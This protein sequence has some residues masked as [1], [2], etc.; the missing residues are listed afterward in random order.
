MRRAPLGIERRLQGTGTQCIIGVQK[1]D[2]LAPGCS[3]TGVA[4]TGNTAVLLM[5]DRHA[6]VP[7]GPG[8]AH[9]PAVVGAAVIDQNTGDRLLRL[10]GDDALHAAV[11]GGHGLVD[12]HDNGD[13]RL[14]HRVPPVSII[15][16]AM[17]TNSA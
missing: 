9:F 4:C 6:G 8:I 11:K 10:L 14:A 5:D 1:N 12:R 3:Q 2:I 13:G 7:R 15:S 17:R 16:C